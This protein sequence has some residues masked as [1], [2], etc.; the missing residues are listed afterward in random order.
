MHLHGRVGRRARGGVLVGASRGSECAIAHHRVRTDVDQRA[1]L[2][3]F[4]HN[5]GGVNARLQLRGGIEAV[6]RAR[7]GAARVGGADHRAIRGAGPFQRDDQAARGRAFRLRRGFA[8]AH[9][10]CFRAAGRFQRRGAAQLLF[11][12]AFKGSAEPLG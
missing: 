5:G 10:G 12:I 1:H 7:K 9:K 3:V 6:Q 4:A 11:A 8:R 2:D